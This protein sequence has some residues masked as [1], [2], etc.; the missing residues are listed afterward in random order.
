MAE[1]SN[2]NNLITS[3][4]RSLGK[5]GSFRTVRATF[6][7]RGGFWREGKG[8]KPTW[9]PKFLFRNVES[10]DKRFG[11]SHF[12]LDYVKDFNKLKKGDIVQFSGVVKM[13]HGKGFKSNYYLSNIQNVL[14]NPDKEE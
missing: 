7:R 8:G 11:T 2:L 10:L 3:Q 5:E 4:K 12:W 13:Y 9:E 14:I 1:R 6:I